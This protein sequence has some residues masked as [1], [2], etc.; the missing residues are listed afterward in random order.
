MT[1][2]EQDTLLKLVTWNV[3]RASISHF[4]DQLDALQTRTPDI[5]ALQEVGVK[6][7]RQPR[8]KLREQGFEYPLSVVP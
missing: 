3:S 4:R 2:A 5:V 1:S 8:K 6:A 7:S